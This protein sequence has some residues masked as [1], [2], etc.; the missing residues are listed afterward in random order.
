MRRTYLDQNAL[1]ELGR[2]SRCAEFRTRLDIAIDSG[3]LRIIASIA[4]LIETAHTSNRKN[5][6]ALV[7]FLESLKPEWLVLNP[8]RLEIRE[9]FYRFANL[10]YLP[11]QRIVGG[12]AGFCGGIGRNYLQKMTQKQFVEELLNQPGHL[13][14]FE[15][16]CRFSVEASRG[17]RKDS[18]AGKI[19]PERNRRALERAVRADVPNNTPVGLE[20][21]QEL[22][23][24]YVR[25]VTAS[26]VPTLA[27]EWAIS[28]Y[29]QGRN[30]YADRNTVIDKLCLFYAPPYVDEIVSND[31]LFWIAYPVAEKT[32]VVKAQLIKNEAFIAR[33]EM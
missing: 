12:Q 25:Q 32:G 8:R 33:F 10:R 14:G 7:E 13:N 18:R 24:E 29:L 11:T 31:K 9:D 26:A 4:H 3:S 23:E 21:G 20:F 19:S 30:D 15:D 5:A 1:I 27:I 22:K 28:E 2:K 6:I 16:M 17:V